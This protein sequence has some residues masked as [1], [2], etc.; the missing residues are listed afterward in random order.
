MG[1]LDTGTANTSQINTTSTTNTAPTNTD[2]SKWGKHDQALYFMGNLVSQTPN[3]STA[4]ID[5]IN[6]AMSNL[7][8]LTNAASNMSGGIQNTFN[9]IMQQ[10]TNARN[11]TANKVSNAFTNA[12]SGVTGSLN[13]ANSMKN[14]FYD[15]L[16]QGVGLIGNAGTTAQNEYAR[17]QPSFDNLNSQL[18]SL[19]GQAT[20]LSGTAQNVATDNVDNIWNQYLQGNQF[21]NDALQRTQTGQLSD[22][23]QNWLNQIRDTQLNAV[24]QQIDKDYAEKERQAIDTLAGRGIVSSG[25]T[26]NALSEAMKNAQDNKTAAYN[27]IMNQYAQNAIQL[28]FTQLDAAKNAYLGANTGSALTGQTVQNLGQAGNVLQQAAQTGST[29]ADLLTKLLG[30]AVNIG[31]LQTQAGNA[32][33]NNATQY[34]TPSNTTANLSNILASMGNAYGNTQYTAD[35]NLANALTNTAN[36]GYNNQMS[37]YNQIAQ[38]LQTSPALLNSMF[39]QYGT[40]SN[41]FVTN[42]L[43][44]YLKQKEIDAYLK[45]AKIKADSTNAATDAQSDAAM[46]GAIGGLLGGLF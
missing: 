37:S 44:N 15:I 23:T 11:D 18:A 34:F 32:L 35:N 26:A 17:L 19:F 8:N 24:N 2:P 38:L 5:A 46:W 27:Q 28:P 22:A 25:V 7:G 16:N 31:G 6:K 41:N 13:E 3:I 4:Y 10:A 43:N 14:N 12:A 21:F 39:N 42:V 45:A 40:L 29:Q 9:N 36:S 20:G 33:A 1:L 30:N